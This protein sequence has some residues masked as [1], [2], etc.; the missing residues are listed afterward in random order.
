MGWSLIASPLARSVNDPVSR[1][2]RRYS[3]ATPQVPRHKIAKTTPCKV[4]WA[5]ACSTQAACV[6]VT[7]WS[8][9]TAPP[10]LILLLKPRDGA[11]RRC[12]SCVANGESGRVPHKCNVASG[13]AF[14]AATV[15]ARP[16]EARIGARSGN[17]MHPSFTG[18]PLN[19]ESCYEVRPRLPAVTSVPHNP[20]GPPLDT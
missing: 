15:Q 17:A 6:R 2:Q 10:N 1:A 5:L 9:V 18:K 13:A 14:N 11:G 19:G 3:S 20:R 12:L 7:R 8:V 4:A 16:A